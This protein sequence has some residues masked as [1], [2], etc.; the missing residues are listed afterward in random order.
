MSDTALLE[1]RFFT[2]RPGTR[3]EFDRVSR[4]GT[5]PLMRRC[6]IEVLAHGPMLND[7]DGYCLVRVFES[8][9]DRLAR[10]GSMY[11]TDEWKD[12]YEEPV[13]AMMADYR[14]AVIEVPRHAVHA[15][16]SALLS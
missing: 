15:Y 16:A 5:V 3:A 10:G 14:T 12:V 1:I 2:T 13:T 6:G 8:E 7:D 4:D 11:E 9:Q